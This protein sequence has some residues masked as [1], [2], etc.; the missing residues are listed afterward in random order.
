[1]LF[2]SGLS[3]TTDVDLLKEVFGSFGKIVDGR[4]II[5]QLNHFSIGFS[6][7]C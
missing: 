6:S 2:F 1:M 3:P 4:Y 5:L 7:H